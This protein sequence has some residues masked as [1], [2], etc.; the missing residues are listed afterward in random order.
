MLLRRG[1]DRCP[2]S[3]V[4][5]AAANVPRHTIVNLLICGMWSA[6]EN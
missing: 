4:S 5:A 2:D 6:G 1:F 3:L